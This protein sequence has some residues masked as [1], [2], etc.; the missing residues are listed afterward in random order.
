MDAKTIE[1][2]TVPKLRDAALKFGD[3][4]GVHGMNKAQLVEILKQK[5]G[6]IE[7]R[8]ENEALAEKRHLLKK[9]I[10]ALKV[11]KTQARQDKNPEKAAVL[12][13]R[14]RQQRRTLK[15]AVKQVKAKK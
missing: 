1:K 7:A 11:Q 12:R 5:H 13:K 14:L 10:R 8:T 6:I 3:L 9:K 15:K 4:T 2:L